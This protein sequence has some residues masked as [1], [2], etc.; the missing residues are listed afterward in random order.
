MKNIQ[1][2]IFDLGNT[3]MYF[4]GEWPAVL[5]EARQAALDAFHQSGV[6]VEIKPF[7]NVFRETLESHYARREDDLVEQT[8][9]S[10]LRDVLKGLGYADLPDSGIDAARRAFYS[11]TQNRWLPEMDAVPTVQMLWDGGYRMGIISN[12]ADDWDVQTLVDKVG[13]RPYM[14]FVLTSAAF[15]QRKPSPSIFRA[16]LAY[17]GLPPENVAMIGDTLNADIL[18]A[19]QVGMLSVW[20]TRR[21]TSLEQQKNDRIQPDAVIEELGEL[22]RVLS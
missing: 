19:N 13:I 10:L 17:W 8:T 14:D 6:A 7:L 16:A 20:I 9:S 1:A 15:G 21:V 11:A 12:A 2:I 4:N 18:G 22:F 5:A 3:L